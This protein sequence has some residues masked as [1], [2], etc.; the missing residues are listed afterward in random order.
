MKVVKNSE[1]GK[2]TVAV[3]GNIDTVTSPTLEAELSLDG[4]SELVMDFA[5]VE[6]VSS[7]GLRLLVKAFKEMSARG[8]AMKIANVRPIVREVFDITGFA[9]RFMFV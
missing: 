9:D 3:E 2:L 4:V 6:Y 7:A 5:G 8:G 1:N